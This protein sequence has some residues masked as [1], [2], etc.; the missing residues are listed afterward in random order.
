MQILGLMAGTSLDGIDAALCDISGQ[1]AALT[2][3]LLAFD[4]VP[5]EP[6]LRE[7]LGR[8]CRNEAD[9][10]EIARLNVEVGE[11]FARVAL[12][13]FAQHGRAEVIASH[14]QT[15]V[16]LPAEGASLQLGEG[17]VIAER[18]GASVVCNFRARDLA[19]GGQ[20]APLVPYC[21]WVLLRSATRNRVVLN[22]GGIANLTVLPANCA[23][24]QVRA[25]DTGPGNMVIDALAQELFGVPFDDGGALAAKGDFAAFERSEL[26]R[27]H[28]FFGQTP[29][30][31]AGRE[32]FGAHFAALFEG[33]PPHDALAAATRL[34][35]HSIA[36]S[37][38]DFSGFARGDYE[39]IASGGGVRNA[40]L[41]RLL[42]E[43]I[44][45]APLRR[46]EEFGH[47]PDA[48]EALCFAILGRETLRGT[49]T[50]VPGA[51][52][53]RAAR[54]LGQIVPGTNFNSLA[55]LR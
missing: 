31:S 38:E 21:D 7:R 20:G 43:E 16:H 50:S 18:T 39:L 24:E 48:K 6:T 3:R 37:I 51:T 17:A 36:A 29:P 40:T 2:A 22:I 47:N 45:P 55:A 12:G 13:V 54:V 25:W 42:A 10:R 4:C 53:G 49:P 35:A 11:A 14:G 46:L 1:G 34:T 15:I 52:G 26:A 23:L 19:A 41:M 9:A 32:E 5:Y 8:A 27:L 44:A 28:P 30:K 33:R